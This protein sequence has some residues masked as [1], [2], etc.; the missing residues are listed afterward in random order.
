MLFPNQ[1]VNIR[2]LV[3]TLKDTIRV[4][5]P[6]VQRGEPG[7]FVYLVEPNNTV[8]VRKIKVGPIDGTYQAV[9]SGLQVGDRVVTEG[10]DRLRDGAA[11]VVPAAGSADAPAG[12]DAAM[13]GAGTARP[14][15][16]G[17]RRAGASRAPAPSG[18]E[19]R[20]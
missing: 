5:V 10:T 13:A 6:A 18:P 19:Q 14:G 9:L 7:T 8:S 16:A 12:Q 20:Q 15:T 2:L 1:F 3:G 17:G 11:V 4:P